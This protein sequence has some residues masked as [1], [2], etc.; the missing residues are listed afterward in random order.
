MDRNLARVIPM[1]GAL[2][3]RELGGLPVSGG[4]MIRHGSL[5]RAGRLSDMT[6]QDKENLQKWNLTKIIDMRNN[7]EVFEHPDP[8]LPGV[9][10]VQLSIFPGGAAGISREDNGETLM[11]KAMR[12]AEMY[13][14]GRARKLLESMYPRMVQEAFCVGQIRTFFRLLA[15][16]E[17]GALAWHC[18]SGKDRTGLTGALL[19]YVLGASRET[20][21]E[22]YLYTNEQIRE[23]RMTLLDGLRERQV[24]PEKIEQIRVLESVEEGYLD[25]CLT[26][27]V[28]TYGSLETFIDDHLGITEEVKK[29]LRDKYTEPLQM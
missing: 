28:E 14:G 21:L 20:I 9:T 8:E 1:E 2:N 29:V 17:G 6:L 22:D 27:I 5:I 23:Y 25:R 19:L 16:H 10:W 26:A 24:D 11:D 7:Q 18:V 15:E 3:V 13:S 12:L 4:R